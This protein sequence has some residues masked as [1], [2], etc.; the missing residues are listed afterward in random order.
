MDI[1]GVQLVGTITI[2]ASGVVSLIPVLS[3]SPFK[4][5]SLTLIPA[6]QD[7]PYKVDVYAN[8]E[9]LESHVEANANDRVITFMNYPDHIWPA[10][11][12]TDAIP[13]FVDPAKQDPSGVAIRVTIENYATVQKTFLLYALFEA[14]DHC[15]F[16]I[17]RQEE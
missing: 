2:A 5:L 14:F 4:N 11:I 16:G 9:L 1:V 6:E 13:A 10:N 7:S 12:G 17:I 8:G 15:R 3:N